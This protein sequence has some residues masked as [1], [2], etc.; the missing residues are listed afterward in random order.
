[1]KI[2][3]LIASHN[4]RDATL[5]CM[6]RLLPQ[7]G[8]DDGVYLVDDGSCDGTTA[9][10]AELNDKRTK[11]INGDGSLFWAKGMRKAWEAA[12]AESQDWDGYLWLN[13]DMELRLDAI[14]K[15]MDVNDGE[16]VVVGELENAKGEIVYG[17]RPGGLF[18]GNCVLVPRKVYE[19]LGMICGEYS[20]AWADSDYAMRAKR[21]GIGIVSAGVVG[22][23]EGHPNRP[24]LKGL[25]LRE[26]IGML[27]NP[28][29]WN[30]HDLWLYRQRNWGCCV[31]VAS[32]LHMIG[33]VIIGE[34]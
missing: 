17:M 27:R 11:V 20:H 16:S 25:I 12:D 2:A 3:V 22:K 28:K 31:A 34:R 30:L 5:G 13:D 23:A 6:S 24:S 9:A 15:M 29:G 1:M 33:H 18:T 7:L 26:R 8:A 4:R 32:C 14:A 21:A 19:R 10:V